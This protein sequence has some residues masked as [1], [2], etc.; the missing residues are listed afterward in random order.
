MNVKTS[1]KKPPEQ[2][3]WWCSGNTYLFKDGHVLT[4]PAKQTK[5]AAANLWW[6]VIQY[7]SYKQLFGFDEWAL[8]IRLE[9]KKEGNAATSIASYNL[10]YT[11]RT[12][13]NPQF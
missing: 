2:L 12:P 3:G 7:G 8:P 9:E 6:K 4:L 11:S 10:Y 1:T 13:H 5:A